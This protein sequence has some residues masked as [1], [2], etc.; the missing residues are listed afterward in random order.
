MLSM[1]RHVSEGTIFHPSPELHGGGGG[2]ARDDWELTV[3]KDGT[4]GGRQHHPRGLEAMREQDTADSNT[5][6]NGVLGKLEGVRGNWD[7]GQLGLGAFI[8]GLSNVRMRIPSSDGRKHNWRVLQKFWRVSCYHVF[9]MN[10]VMC[11]Y[12]LTIGKMLV[13][14]WCHIF[15]MPQVA[16]RTFWQS[17]IIARAAPNRMR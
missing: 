14:C 7:V 17:V 12:G 1:R 3:E 8:R 9:K 6:C 2:G 10:R 13:L 5:L 11:L 15:K 4:M 16:P